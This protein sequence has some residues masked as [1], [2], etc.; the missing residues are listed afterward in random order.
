MFK[1]MNKQR[2]KKG[3]T[4]IELIVVIAILGILALIA[5]PRFTNVTNSAKDKA[6][7]ADQRV[8][9]AA[10]Q[11]YLAESDGALPTQDSDIEPYIQ[12]DAIPST[13]SV[14]YNTTATPPNVTVSATSAGGTDP[15]DVV[16]E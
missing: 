6:A 10:V 5:I 9:V 8:V 11:M 16:I 3:F 12:G 13:V 2:N 15:A 1:L 7:L 4:L 14:A